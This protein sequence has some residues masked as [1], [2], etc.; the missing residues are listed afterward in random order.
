MSSLQMSVSSP[1]R[2]ARSGAA[3]GAVWRAC[4]L[5][6]ASSAWRLAASAASLCLRASLSCAA[7]AG[8]ARYLRSPELSCQ[9]PVSAC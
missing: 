7:Y 5:V 1:T 3:T 9:R 8:V 4:S 2:S 6:S